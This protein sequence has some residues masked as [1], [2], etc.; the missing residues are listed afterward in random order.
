MYLDIQTFHLKP[1][2]LS[3]SQ[4]HM[5]IRVV[6]PMQLKIV[7]F[8]ETKKQLHHWK[9]KGLGI[10]TIRCDIAV[11]NKALQ[12]RS[13][14]D[15]PQQNHLAEI[16]ITNVNNKGHALIYHAHVPEDMK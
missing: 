2:E 14:S 3:Y 10:D 9:E 16:A 5:Y 15:T 7:C 4:P 8:H 12:L 6:E 13:E 1:K 11:E